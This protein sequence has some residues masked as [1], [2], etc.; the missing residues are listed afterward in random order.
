[1]D[2]RCAMCHLPF[3]DCHFYN[4][5]YFKKTTQKTKSVIITLVITIL[6]EALLVVWFANYYSKPVSSLLL[7]SMLANI[8]TQSL[9]WLTL[10]FSPLDYLITLIFTEICIFLIEAFILFII[11][12]NQLTFRQALVLSLGINLASFTIGWFIPV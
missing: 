10:A 1:M 11:F 3:R 5:D 12:T 7:S 2:I 9:L 6:I 4:G 8:F